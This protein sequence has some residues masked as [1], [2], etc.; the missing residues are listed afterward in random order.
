MSSVA[1]WNL[2]AF[3]ATVGL[4]A[5]VAWLPRASSEREGPSTAGAASPATLRDHRGVL[6]RAAPYRRIASASPIA[7]T[8]LLELCEPD[9]IVA[10]TPY[11]GRSRNFRYAG[12]PTVRVEDLESILALH[13]DLVLVS[14]IGDAQPIERLRDAGLVV[15]DLGEPHGM[16]TLVPNVRELADLIDAGERGSELATR[17]T[18]GMRLVAADVPRHRRRRAIYLSVFAGRLFGGAAGT[19]YDDVLAAAG[20][21]DAA[22]G[23]RGWPSY[24]TDDVLEMDPDVIVTAVGMR[25]RVCEHAGL[26]ALRACRSP[27]RPGEGGDLPRPGE[28]G[29]FLGIVEV[30]GPLLS[31]PG[32]AMVDA[33]R[34]V[35]DVVYGPP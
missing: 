28:A 25:R 15:Y 18:E 5:S 21:V 31:D 3:V 10:F 4:S 12:K 7:D 13:P 8:L 9:R 29:D 20:L 22:E 1:A 17:L 26:E 24:S 35:R 19:S 32:L 2:A 14:G 34:I 16:Q 23:Y 27:A 30:D 33:A 11:S 6:V